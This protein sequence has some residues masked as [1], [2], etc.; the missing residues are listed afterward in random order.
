MTL[1][2]GASIR[3][4]GI[5]NIAIFLALF[6]PDL[7][8]YGYPAGLRHHIQWGGLTVYFVSSLSQLFVAAR[9][10]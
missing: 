3:L 8:G 7:L 4:W 10:R 2:R 9:S 1:S 5:A 6:V